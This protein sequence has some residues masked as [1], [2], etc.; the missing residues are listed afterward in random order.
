MN[1]KLLRIAGVV[2]VAALA[3]TQ[4]WAQ[5]NVSPEVLAQI[6]AVSSIKANFTP[7][8]KKMDS[9][10][11]YGA[12]AATNDARVATIR[13]AIAPVDA[14]GVTVEIRGTVGPDLLAAIAAANGTVV[15]SSARWGAVTAKLPAGALEGIAA[16][17]DVAQMR[18]P[19]RKRTNAGLVTS[20]GYVPHQANAAIAMGYTGAGIKV[21]VLS[22]SASA[23][24][25]APLITSGDL[26]VGTTSL[27][28]QSGEPGTDEGTAMMEIVHD[29]A[30]GAQLLFATA[31]ISPASFADNIIALAAAGCK[32]I[33]DDVSYSDEGVFQDSII[34][35]AVNQVTASGVVYFSSAANSGNLSHGTSTTWEGDFLDGGAVTGPIAAAGETGNFHNFNTP[36]SPQNYNVLLQAT[37][38]VSLRWS[39]PLGASS[40]DY[41]LFV[42][43]STGTTLLG[44]SAAVQNGT[45]DPD[46]EI[47]LP[48]GSFPAGSRV[49][50]VLFS[51]AQRALH[52]ETFGEARLSIATD[53]ATS[54]HNA[55]NN[56]VSMAATF[57]N[58]AKTGTT[59]FTGANNPT[60]VFSSDGPRKIFYNPN[61]TAIT[62]GNFLF[63]TNGGT[64]LVKPDLAAANG[65]TALT[66]GFSPFF[67]TSA[68]APHAAAIA[69]LVRQARPDYTVAQVKTAMTATALDSMGPGVDRDSGYGIAMA[70]AAVQY[71]L[72]H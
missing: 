5:Q 42:L 17:T 6:Q 33:V 50:V 22:D 45:Q 13:G 48:S 58:S 2:A 71:A 10:L 32:V 36:G 15:Y 9:A 20:Q 35:Q 39:D 8:Q 47:Y 49:V 37:N 60:E 38:D 29:I 31:F 40:N 23:A 51:G 63:G 7:A 14:A 34:A 54:G 19:A 55:A 62:P 44:F 30:P 67:G 26:P 24:S 64:T 56:T 57:W 68:S 1:R 59:A 12:M 28:G 72:S 70:K 11:A 21:G 3:C 65:T 69:A 43:N 18:L 52:V 53:G 25:I 4:A 16:R 41:D 46:E 61:G 27:P 66:P